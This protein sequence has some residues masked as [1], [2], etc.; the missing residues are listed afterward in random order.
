MATKLNE[1]V[2]KPI[3]TQE[4]E[5]LGKKVILKELTTKD[6]LEMDYS[7]F[8]TEN[9]NVKDILK[10]ALDIL[11]YS[12]VSIDGIV[13]EN[14][15]ETREFLL[16]QEQSIVLDLLTKYQSILEEGKEEIKK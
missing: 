15:K 3:L 8:Q 11:S 10:M 13:P 14:A 12:I 7:S 2:F 5:V 9:V 4:F 16:N 6:N 1:I